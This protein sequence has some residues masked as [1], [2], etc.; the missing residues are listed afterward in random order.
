MSTSELRDEFLRLLTQDS[1]TNDRRRKEFNQA[2]FNAEQGWAI[3]NQTTLDMV[4][5]KF[6]KAVQNLGDLYGD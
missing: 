5:S 1:E 2:L 3:W 4:M 6:D